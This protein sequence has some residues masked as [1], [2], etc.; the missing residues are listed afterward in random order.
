MRHKLDSLNILTVQS[1]SQLTGVSAHVI[2]IWERRYKALEPER[3]KTGRR[4]YGEN[5]VIRLKLLKELTEIHSIGRIANLTTPELHHLAVRTVESERIPTAKPETSVLKGAIEALEDF[6]VDDLVKILE[7]SEKSFPLA[8]YLLDVVSPLFSA[9]GARVANKQLSIAHEHLLS[10]L[11]RDQLGRFLHSLN[12]TN[13]KAKEAVA[14]AT[15]SGDM[16]EFGILISAILFALN[17]FRIHYFGPNLPADVLGQAARALK[18]THVT[19]GVAFESGDETQI[20]SYLQS[21]RERAG[22]DIT[23]F[24][25][26]SA[27]V[28]TKTLRQTSAV[29]LLSLRDLLKRIERPL[30]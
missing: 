14:L 11:L 8:D 25:G 4:I 24:V 27:T 26:G 23:L 30:T 2:R 13:S 7:R 22:D 12:S 15:P 20:K 9:V 21:F 3:G 6:R 1:L 29:H 18:C 19:L 16:H 28:A 10:A 5:D 17:G